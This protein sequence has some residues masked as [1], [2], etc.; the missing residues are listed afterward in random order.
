MPAQN[1]EEARDR[2][3]HWA[4]R[5]LEGIYFGSIDQVLHESFAES[6]VCWMF[7]ISRSIVIPPERSLSRSAYAI[8]RRTGEGRSIPDF[9]DDPKALADYLRVISEYFSRP[10]EEGK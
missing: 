7:F 10:L 5:D 9:F 6:D 2:A 8:S 3:K 4:I 1:L